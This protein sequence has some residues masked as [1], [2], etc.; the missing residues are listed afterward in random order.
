MS[1]P[2]WLARVTVQSGDRVGVVQGSGTPHILAEV[3][4]YEMRITSP[5]L[6]RA[7]LIGV[8]NVRKENLHHP[9]N[10]ERVER[11]V[12]AMQALSDLGVQSRSPSEI[13]WLALPDAEEA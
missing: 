5:S 9:R 11:M 2:E 1:A 7:G 6:I 13:L 4:S 12:A 3:D 8:V 10:V